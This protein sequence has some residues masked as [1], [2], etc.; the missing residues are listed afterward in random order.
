MLWDQGVTCLRYLTYRQ[1]KPQ[2]LYTVRFKMMAEE[3]LSNGFENTVYFN[4]PRFELFYQNKN[5]TKQL[6]GNHYVCRAH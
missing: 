2:S 5:Y 3:C 1:L 4:F 6:L